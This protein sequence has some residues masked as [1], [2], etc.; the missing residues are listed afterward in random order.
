[1]R[2][3]IADANQLFPNRKRS[4]TV[5]VPYIGVTGFMSRD[6]VA[7]VLKVFPNDSKRK[8][9]IGVLM[10]EKTLWGI[11]NKW[12][13]RY[14]KPEN[15]AGIFPKDSRALNLIHL[16]TEE[17]M[18]LFDQLVKV[19]ALGGENLHGFQLNMFWPD[20]GAL[21]RYRERNPSHTLVL[22]CGRGALDSVQNDP[23]SF[24][25]SVSA[26]KGVCDF[27]LI[28]PSGVQ[29]KPFIPETML[30]L[31]DRLSGNLDG[32]MGIGV[33]GGLGMPGETTRLLRPIFDNF[34][35][36]SVDAEG[37]LRDMPNNTL[38]VERACNFVQEVSRLCR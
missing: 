19:S 24:A 21:E 11:P 9:M 32:V 13:N 38:N 18:R 33:A 12:L 16:H 34:P 37:K 14:S 7:Y 1:M 3:P 27:V 28:D 22:Q 29:G 6:E 31:L 26:Y 36:T 20:A 25:R 17:R 23:E 4:N 5:N 30:A 35:N 8:L 15:I 10:N 2:C